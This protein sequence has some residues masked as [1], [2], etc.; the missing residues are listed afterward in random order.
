M[1]SMKKMVFILTLLVGVSAISCSGQSNTD[2]QSK[3]IAETEKKE[4]K[5]K[6]IHLTKA[7]FL[8]KVA[9]YETTPNE[10][11]YL[12]DKP[13]LIDFYADWCGPCK[14]IAPVLEELAAEYAG[15]IYIYK[16]DTEAEQEL[17]AVFG[18]RS[19]P[20]LLFVPM[21]EDPQMAQGALPKPQLKEAIDKVLLK[22]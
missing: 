21:G 5:M 19:I 3:K 11:K 8:S 20:S 12:G 10:W 1:K 18:I 16:I 13:A 15:E 9:N 6:T 22:K 4:T 2:K 14:A 17:A 7:D